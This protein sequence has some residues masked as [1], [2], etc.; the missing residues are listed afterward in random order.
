MADFPRSWTILGHAIRYVT[1]LG[2]QLRV[3]ARS[4]S[5]YQKNIRA[6]T[7][8]ALYALE[9]TLAEFTGRP[10][11]ITISDISAPIV[12]MREKPEFSTDQQA[13]LVDGVPDASY[14]ALASA[15]PPKDTRSKH[16]SYRVQLSL[17]SH[18]ICSSLYSIAQEMSWSKVQDSIRQLDLEL[19][20]WRSRLPAELTTV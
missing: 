8:Y 17:L 13:L 4:I 7:W 5:G 3:T 16:F 14:A 10:C 20:R 6:R 9:I 19:Q 12:A 1:A 11:S 18:R 2:L 15:K